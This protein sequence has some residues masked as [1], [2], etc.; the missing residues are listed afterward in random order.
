MPIVST[1]I[2]GQGR[3][4]DGIHLR[5]KMTDQHGVEHI[6]S[7]TVPNGTDLNALIVK[8]RAKL[9][10]SLI[11]AELQKAVYGESWDYVLQHA[12]PTQLRDYARKEYQEKNYP[13][14]RTSIAHRLEEWIDNGRFT[15]AEIRASFG[16]DNAE[17]AQFRIRLKALRDADDLVRNS[18]GE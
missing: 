9:E 16:K 8:K 18:K 4:S 6:Y 10:R 15:V 13:E 5:V 12:S 3:F 2:L 1:E 11:D 14:L 17:F 7:R